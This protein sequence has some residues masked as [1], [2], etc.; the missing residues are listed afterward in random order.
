VKKKSRAMKSKPI[1]LP[2]RLSIAQSADLHRTLAACCEAQ[3]PLVLDGSCVEDI[4]TAILQL[5]VSAWLGAAK[6]GV[7]CR[8]QGASDSLRHAAT[9]IGVAAALQLDGVAAATGASAVG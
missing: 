5:L 1:E 3:V 8:W 6:R 9:L 4:D 7:E 2:A